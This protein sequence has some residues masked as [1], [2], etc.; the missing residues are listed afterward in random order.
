MGDISFS[1]ADL[2][3]ASQDMFQFVKYS[4]TD[5]SVTSNLLCSFV[6]IILDSVHVNLSLY[7]LFNIWVKTNPLLMGWGPHKHYPF[8]ELIILFIKAVKLLIIMSS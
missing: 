7:E 4:S 8:H 6:Q 2:L 5:R 1:E 3:P